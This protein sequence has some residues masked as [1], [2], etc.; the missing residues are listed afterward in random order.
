MSKSF[1][2][3]GREV[4]GGAAPYV[5]AEMSANHNG[6]L[7]TALR[8]VEAAR[9]AGADAVKLQTYTPDT[10]TLDSDGEDFQIADGPWRGRTLHDLYQEAYLPWE[11]HRPLFEHARRLGLSIFSSPFDASAVDLLEELGAPAYKIASLEVVDLPLIRYA[12]ATGKPLIISTGLADAGEI[13]EAIDAARSAGCRDLAILHCVTAYPA[14]ASDYN[15][16]T[17]ADMAQRFDAV[18]G[19]SDH[20]LDDVTA[21]S[22]VAFGAAIVEKHFTLDRGGNGPDDPFSLEPA[23]LAGLCRA[24]RTAWEAAGSVDYGLKSSERAN[25]KYRR[26]LYF[27]RDLA[28]GDVVTAECV[29]SVRP[30]FGLPPKFLDQ[31]VGRRAARALRA[32]TRVSWE[33]LEP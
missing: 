26:S 18:V 13:G 17:I 14:P 10:I 1:R 9:E 4:G 27:T 33:D 2:I 5:V 19:L 6:S 32:N 22:A 25:V 3:D 30:G 23:Q 20:T 15:L 7:D 8:I 12:A 11:W 29:R 24:V 16:R 21:I 31:V 28:A